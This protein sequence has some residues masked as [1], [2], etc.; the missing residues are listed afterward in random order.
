MTMSTMILLMME[1]MMF[2]VIRM[3]CSSLQ[4]VLDY[5]GDVEADMCMTFQVM[6]IIMMLIIIIVMISMNIM[7]IIIAMITMRIMIIINLIIIAPLRSLLVSMGRSKQS[8]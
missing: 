1:M 4:N 2:I 5:E 6:M 3:N 7:M 8:T